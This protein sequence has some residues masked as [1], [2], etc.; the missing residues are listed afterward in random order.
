MQSHLSEGVPVGRKER[1]TTAATQGNKHHREAQHRRKILTISDK[2]VLLFGLLR[3]FSREPDLEVCGEANSASSALEQTA[4]LRPD[5]AMIALPLG[6]G[7]QFEL[8]AELKAKHLPLKVLAGFRQEDSGIMS[9]AFHAGADGCL[10]WGDPLTQLVEAAHTV[11]AGDVYVGSRSGKRLLKHA[12]SGNSP[13]DHGVESLTNREWN[14]LVM[15]GQGL[16]TR[17]IA[18]TLDVSTR[19]V[20]SHRKKIKIKLRLQNAAQLN[21]IAYQSWQQVQ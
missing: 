18:S 10:C 1:Q 4:S 14:V 2:P 9:R 5:M 6:D 20:E 15:I 3:L 8:I 19:T 11:L 7:M 13:A 16:T 17:Q 12:L 21:H